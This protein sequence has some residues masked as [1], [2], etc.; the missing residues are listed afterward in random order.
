MR[1]TKWGAA[2]G[3][4]LLVGAIALA[5]PAAAQDEHFPAGGWEVR[6]VATGDTDWSPAAASQVVDAATVELIKPDGTIGTS[7][8]TTNLGLASSAG[9]MITVEYALSGG[10][11]TAAGA[12]RLFY[13][14]TPD[15]DTLGAAP[16]AFVAADGSGALSLEVVADGEIGTLGLTY[17]ASNDTAGTVTFSN[18]AVGKTEIRFVQPEQLD[19]DPPADELNCDDFATQ[20]E[21]QAVLDADPSDPHGLDG[22]GDGIA[23]ESLPSGGQ[24]GGSGNDDDDKDSLPVT[25]VSTPL[26]AGGAV[27]L[28]AAGGVLW[29]AA[30]RRRV[31]FTA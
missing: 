4:G 5:G 29:F 7:I 15:A 6:Q 26:I 18:L 23:C 30:R 9:D 19:P 3:L 28:L 31:T 25:G 2:A 11:D 14:D 27:A 12:I 16:T 22:D 10:A 13:Y 17:D 20:E 21:A 24:A 1:A 8:E